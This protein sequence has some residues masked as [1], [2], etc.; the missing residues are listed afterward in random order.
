MTPEIEVYSVT[1]AAEGLAI[2][3]RE[4]PTDVRVQGALIAS[5]QLQL[6]AGHPDY[7]ED[8]EKLQNRAVKVLKNALEDFRD[9]EPY[10]PDEEDDDDEKGM[11]E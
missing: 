6:H 1:F 8:I 9:S 4:L 11:G 7:R 10:V 5:H 3:Y 2:E